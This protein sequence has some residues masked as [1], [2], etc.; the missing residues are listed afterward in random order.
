MVISEKWSTGI[1]AVC[2]ESH[3]ACLTTG[4]VITDGSAWLL[5]EKL[6]VSTIKSVSQNSEVNNFTPAHSNV[7]V[8]V[9]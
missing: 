7:N 1:Y 2:S 9:P 8:V 6:A 5:F 3:E 4:K